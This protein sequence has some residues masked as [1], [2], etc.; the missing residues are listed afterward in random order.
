[1]VMTEQ[2]RPKTSPWAVALAGVV[3]LGAWVATP[4]RSA[5]PESEPVVAADAAVETSEPDPSPKLAA[6]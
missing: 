6:E 5:P 3:A 4:A 2:M 1:M